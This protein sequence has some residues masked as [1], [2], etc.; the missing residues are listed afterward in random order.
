MK[1][2][3]NFKFNCKNTNK[4][5]NFY[6]FLS[7]GSNIGN[8]I[9]NIDTAIEKLK[10]IGCKILQIAP[11]Y[12]TKPLLPDDA[13]KNYNK[14][15]YNTVIEIETNFEPHEFLKKI[16]QIELKM[17][18]PKKHQHWSPR[19]IDIDILY[20]KQGIKPIFIAE[21]TLSIPHKEI[22]NR[23]FVLDPLAQ[24][25]PNLVINSKNILS[26]SKKHRQHQS[27]K[28]KIINI[29]NNSFSGDGITD[30]MEIEKKIK[31][32]T[33]KRV[34]FI[35]IGAESTN[36]LAKPI[37]SKE[38]I[39]RLKKSNII[40]TIKK[41]KTNG[42]KFSIDTYH[43]ETAD[44]AIKNGFDV[45]NDVNGFKD[46][47]MWNIMQKNN[48]ICAV[49]MHSIVPNGTKK[50]CI[51]N[52]INIIEVL[53]KWV[54]NVIEKAN[55][56]KIDKNRIIIDY[57]IGFGKTA[58][59]DLFI[60]NNFNKINNNSLLVLIGHSRKNFLKLLGAKNIDDRKKITKK[61][62]LKLTKHGADILRLH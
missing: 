31:Y 13:D 21:K 5:I 51:N 4:E 39:D 29:N 44:F 52:N 42:V 56:Y 37:S 14:M 41:Y 53:N 19:I 25:A 28:M 49:I 2:M 34:A 22:F 32:L 60:I 33:K 11:Y 30:P 36:P 15:F 7:L 61:V 27:A 23:A 46:E 40:N 59:Q 12:K 47:K 1:S 26:E 6:Y 43:P 17:G 9:K 45:I 24:I 16:K 54:E 10:D 55:F 35:D 38:E 20:C 50:M 48:N 3:N 58:E 57:G 18:R 62:S 8:K